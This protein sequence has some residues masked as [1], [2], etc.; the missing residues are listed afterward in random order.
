MNIPAVWI[1]ACAGMTIED[2]PQVANPVQVWIPACAGMT[3]EDRPQV[4]NPVRVWIPAC[5]GMTI[6]LPATREAP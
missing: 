4:A 1:P 5:A 2:R 6:A 3:I